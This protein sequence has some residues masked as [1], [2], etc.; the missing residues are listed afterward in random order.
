MK[1]QKSVAVRSLVVLTLLAL[2]LGAALVSVAEG[3]APGTLEFK[4]NNKIYSA[5]GKFERWE[6]VNVELPEGDFEKG[7]VEFSVDLA[8]VW[9]KASGLIDH[10]RTADFFNV[11]EFAKATV[12][13]HSAKKTGED[14]YSATATVDFHGHT[15]DVP[16]TFKVVSTSPLKIEG[17][18][19][20]DRVAFG[21]GGPYDES[22]DKSIVQGI[23][24]SISATLD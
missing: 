15:G 4:A 22:N 11:D 13:V 1:V 3:D 12:K 19:T 21:I 2:S 8:S 24:I 17:T 18:A 5:H 20:L 10:L 6:I 9:E 23:E 16:A 7:S 14:T